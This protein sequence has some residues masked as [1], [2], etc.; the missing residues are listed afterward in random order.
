[1]T[2]NS[3]TGGRGEP[4][5]TVFVLVHGAWHASWQW[6]AT[7]RAMAG[8]GVASVAVD[9]PGHGFGAPLPS[10]YL[11]PG[12]PGLSTEKS[13]LAAMTVDDFA[14]AIIDTLRRVRGYRTVVLVSHSAGGG[15]ASLAAERAP[16]LV[17]RMV[18]LSA[19]VPAGR[20]R[21]FDYLSTEQNAD[22]L[23]QGL[24]L[25]DPAAIGAVRINPH[26]GDPAYVEELRRTH[27]HDTPPER[28][29]RWRLALSPDLPL[30]IPSSPVEV[31]RERWGRI[32][33]TYL[34]CGE[35]RAAAP[36]M[37]DLMI[38]EADEAMPDNPFVVVTLASSH[39]PFAAH[40]VELANELIAA[41]GLRPDAPLR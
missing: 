10:G 7:Q 27:Y 40:P 18:Y 20:P 1:M 21:F 31:T 13:A 28:F 14:D 4:F 8:A 33:R 41:A 30:A 9:L 15:P 22:A 6:A 38:T 17:D 23:G 37:Q 35:D 12:Q 19:F 3:L 5:G 11:R 34:R 16:E 25:G 26:S 24:Q 39:T 29:D 36:A 2:V 32:P